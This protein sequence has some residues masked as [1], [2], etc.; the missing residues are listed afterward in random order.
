MGLSVQNRRMCPTLDSAL[1]MPER[2]LTVHSQFLLLCVLSWLFLLKYMK[3]TITSSLKSQVYISIL[4]FSL[5]PYASNFQLS[6]VTSLP[7]DPLP[8]IAHQGRILTPTSPLIFHAL[9][10]TI[11]NHAAQVKNLEI[12]LDSY[13]FFPSHLLDHELSL[14]YVPFL[15]DHCSCPIQSLRSSTFPTWTKAIIP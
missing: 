15:L 3:S 8:W 14:T 9:N 5:Q 11:T 4:N 2:W 10:G 13:P 12:I 1:M 6:A 7:T